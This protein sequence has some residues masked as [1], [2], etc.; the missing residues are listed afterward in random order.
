[1]E[2]RNPFGLSVREF[3]GTI[4]E[5]SLEELGPGARLS[6]REPLEPRSFARVA[7]WLAARPGA[8]LRL[9]G[10]AVSQLPE[11]AEAL[12][13][14]LSIDAAGLNLLPT[15]RLLRV[16]SLEI[17]GMPGDLARVLDTFANV[18]A[19]R[20]A[21]RGEPLAPA[22][23]DGREMHVL[24]LSRVGAGPDVAALAGLNGLR[25]LRLYR[26][27]GFARLD[28]IE[29][30]GLLAEL[31]LCGLLGVDDL[32]PLARLPALAA[33]ELTDMWQLDLPA[34]SVLDRL[35]RLSALSVDIGGRRKNVEVYRRLPLPR[36]G[37]FGRSGFAAA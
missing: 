21:A 18:R 34:V 1:L 17:A 23:L 16:R 12:P 19:L 31:A 4:G 8:S 9:H 37:S 5:A 3:R 10:S 7:A 35:C 22:A 15:L 6:W 14:A 11:L 29:H 25:S 36:T 2:T 30:H 13:E 27:E 20:L 24:D 33:L 28:G 26:L 32:E